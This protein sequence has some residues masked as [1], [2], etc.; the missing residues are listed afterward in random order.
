M[1]TRILWLALL[2]CAPGASAQSWPSQPIRILLPYG[3]AGVADITARVIAQKLS[4]SL[5]SR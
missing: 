5:H 1:K 4:D 2:L 3:A